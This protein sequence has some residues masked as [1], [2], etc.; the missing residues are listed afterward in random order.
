MNV[1][2]LWHHTPH[3]AQAQL[4]EYLARAEFPSRANFV[5]ALAPHSTRALT[6]TRDALLNGGHAVSIHEFDPPRQ[7]LRGRGKHERVTVTVQVFL[8]RPAF[9]PRV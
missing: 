2:T 7:P 5:W 3:P 1:V 6:A 8:A 4:A 9:K